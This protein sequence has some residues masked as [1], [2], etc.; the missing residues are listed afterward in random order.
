M[1]S[2]DVVV[3]GGGS[4]GETLAQTLAERGRRVALVEE[5][6]VGGE[7][8]YFACMPSKALLQAAGQGMSWQ[9]AVAHRDEV[10]AHRDDSEAAK[11][12]EQAGVDVVR[13]RGVVTG[14]GTVVAGNRELTA[15]DIVIA[16]GA[17]AVV[18]DIAGL[19]REQAWTSEDALSNAEL[20]GRL[21]ILGG[22]AIGCELGQAYACF[23]SQVTIVESADRLLAKEPSFVGAEVAAALRRLGVE[24]RFGTSLE[25]VPDDGTR[26]LVATGKKPRVDGLGLERLGIAPND[27]GALAVDDR[28]RV[29]DHVWAIGDVTGLAPYTHAANYQARVVADNLTGRERHLDLRAIPRMV[30]TDPAVCCIG[31]TGGEPAA[32]M[33]IGET[34][35][36]AVDG[37]D[38]GMVALYVDEAREVLIGA[39]LVGPSVDA[40]A[41]ELTV[42]IRA[43]V[44]VDVLADVVH[45]FPTYSEALHAPYAELAR[46]SG[47]DS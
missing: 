36:A 45:A 46:R 21:L 1:T 35:R 31:N 6:L 33:R 39:A 19:D 28:C 44:P 10:S 16:T 14:A 23:G 15:T 13:A 11:R 32:T 3:I 25:R 29:I 5:R 4:A 2:Y 47:K 42:A 40:W 38:D 27:D 43:E 30:Y 17:E 41:G 8:P 26:L 37:R 18:P 7:C 12:L 24:L 9:Q 20:P 34:A 22:G